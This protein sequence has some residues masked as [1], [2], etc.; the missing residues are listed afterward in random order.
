MDQRIKNKERSTIH[1]QLGKHVHDQ[2]WAHFVEEIE[3][4]AWPEGQWCLG[5]LT[6]SQKRRV[7][8]LRARQ[9]EGDQAQKATNCK[10]DAPSKHATRVSH[11][12]LFIMFFFY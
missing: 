2:N 8:R 1:T 9:M 3:E 6:R 5:G 11:W 4:F 10:C 12:L 7:Q